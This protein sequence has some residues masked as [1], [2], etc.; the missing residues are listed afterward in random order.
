MSDN[1]KLALYQKLTS[2]SKFTIGLNG[3]LVNITQREIY[4]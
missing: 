2:V 1:N 4:R 3:Q